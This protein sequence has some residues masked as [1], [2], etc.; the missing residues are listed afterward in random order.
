[1]IAFAA[2][3]ALGVILLAFSWPALTAEPRE[4]PVA[5]TGQADL[6][7]RAEATLAAEGAAAIELVHLDNRDQVISAIEERDVV[8]AL[9]LDQDA[10]EVLT[11]SGAGSGP[12]QVM[13]A[14]TRQ[15]SAGF[16][17]AGAQ[18]GPPL[19]IKITDVVPL[20]DDDPS[21]NR[22]GLAALP[23]VIGGVLGAAV[24]SLGLVG[25]GRQVVGLIGYA[26]IGG[27][28]I[29]AILQFWYGALQGPY[30]LNSLA[31]TLALLAIAS[32]VLG[33]VR[34]VGPPGVGIGA[35]L[36]VL[37]SNPISG[38]MTPSQF[39]PQPWNAIGLWLPPG[40]SSDLLRNLSYYP[41]APSADN[42]LILAGW[43][44]TGL[45][46]VLLSA[47]RLPQQ[48]R[49]GH[50]EQPGDQVAD[51]HEPVA[52]TPTRSARKSPIHSGVEAAG[53]HGQ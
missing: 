41:D 10:P 8:G 48:V 23:L 13:D 39:L 42:W 24:I 21:G 16:D 45:H 4:V 26:V 34:L 29:G 1:V 7:E 9:V 36:F 31:I 47:L 12:R 5:I 38:S 28:G 52:A 20:S 15:L 53:V 46:L 17:R 14:V 37:G 11:A 50:R 35:A 30:G 33:L 3:A 49:Q 18:Q 2:A 32:P 22:L 40:A 51:H 6:V 19:T 43:A 25:A 27:F 44:V